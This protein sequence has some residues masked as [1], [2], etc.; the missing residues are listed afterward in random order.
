LLKE[1][2]AWRQRRVTQSIA[3]VSTLA[4]F[5]VRAG[6]SVVRLAA[7][8]VRLKPDATTANANR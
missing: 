6:E 1:R 7:G 2:V 5:G 4:I 8:E 3:R